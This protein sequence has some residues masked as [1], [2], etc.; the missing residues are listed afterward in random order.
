V[1]EAYKQRGWNLDPSA[2]AQCE[3]EGRTKEMDEQRGEGC[4]VYGYVAVNKVAGNFHIAP[5]KSYQQGSYVHIHDT[6]MLD[7][8]V[9]V[10]HYVTRLAFGE[11]FPGVVN[12]LDGTTKVDLAG[13]SMFQ[14]FVKIVPTRYTRLDGS[15]ISTN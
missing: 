7:A 13:A 5:G 12:P 9:N 10:S 2:V 4:T 14:Y 1:I 15:T 8:D 11:G 6:H 3:K